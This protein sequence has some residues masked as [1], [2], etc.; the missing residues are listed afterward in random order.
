M[1]GPERVRYEYSADGVDTTA[2]DGVVKYCVSSIADMA[3]ED[4]VG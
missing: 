4:E 2:K 1:A 3:V